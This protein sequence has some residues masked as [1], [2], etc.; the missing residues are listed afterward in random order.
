MVNQ[1]QK[2]TW[3]PRESPAPPDSRVI[4]VPR[5]FQAPRVQSA[6]QEKRVPWVNQASQEC[7]ARTDPR[8]TLAKKALPERKEARVRLAPRVPSVTLVLEESRGQMVSVV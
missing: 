2:E 7:L 8:A 4:L 3:A 1:A 5:V 6:L